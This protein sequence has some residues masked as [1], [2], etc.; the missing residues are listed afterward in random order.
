[1]KIS[2]KEF[3][4][5]SLMSLGE[6]VSTVSSALKVQVEPPVNMPVPDDRTAMPNLEQLAVA[7]NESCLARNGDCRNCAES[8]KSEAIK[9][10]PRVGIRINPRLC[11]GCGTCEYVCPAIPKAVRMKIRT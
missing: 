11:N 7:F 2:R 4:R 5:K 6:A 1:M 3:F 8:C 9:I 10:I